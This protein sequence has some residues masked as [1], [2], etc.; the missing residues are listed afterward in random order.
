MISS[1]VNTLIFRSY[2]EQSSHGRAIS[3]MRDGYYGW[4]GFGGSALQWHPHLKI[5]FGYAPTLM[6]WH[7]APNLKAAA[8]QREVVKC[9]LALKNKL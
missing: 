3:S 6:A 9:A 8:L 7:D 5:G 1:L 2:P 4:L